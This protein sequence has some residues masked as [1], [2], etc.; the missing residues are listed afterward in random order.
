MTSPDLRPVRVGRAVATFL[1]TGLAVLTMVAL[2]LALSQKR[3][4]TAEAIRDARTLTNLEATDVIGPLLTDASLVPGT[5]DHAALAR[6]VES[7]VLG[8]HIVRVKIWDRTGTIRYSDDPALIGQHFG[9]PAEELAVLASG[10][11]QAEVS[12]LNEAENRDER[13]FG[14]L[15]QVYQGVRT[16]SGTR[17]LFETYQPYSVITVASRRL[18]LASLPVLL[19]ALVV[20]YLV[21]APLA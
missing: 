11:T 4:A 12:D 8:T 21:Q 13:R 5:P 15:L 14:K 10:R 16:T 9:L 17:V 7:R 20:L 1:L 6:V 3:N 18:W 2:L 19:A